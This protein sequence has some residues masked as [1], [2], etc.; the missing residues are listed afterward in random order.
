MNTIPSLP[1]NRI[2]VKLKP[3]AERM[4]KKQHPWVFQNS[5][6]KQSMEGKAG[7]LAIIYDAKKNKFLACGLLDPDSPIRIKLLQFATPKT[8]DA[9][10]FADT[11]KSAM[12][13]RKSL[14]TTDTNSYRIL[15]GE[16]DHM[17]GF[18]AD[19]YADVLVIK[20]YSHI[21][22]PYL[23]TIVCNL[24]EITKAKSVVLRMSRL[25]QSKGETFDLQD[26]QLLYG[27]LKNEVILFR[28]HGVVFSAN[29]IHGHKTGYFLDH[30]HNRKRV[31]GMSK[32]KTVLDIFSYA[33]GFSVHALAG[34]AKA[35][36]SL[37]ISQQA[38]ASAQDNA[39]LNTHSGT[40]HIMVADAFEGLAQ[41]ISEKKKFDIV[42]IDPP[43][44]AKRESE[45]L[46]AKQSYAR[47]AKLGVQM[48][49]PS[50]ILVL[51]SCSSRVTAEEFFEISESELYRSGRNFN[52]IDK[53]YH[54][55]DHPIAFPEGAYLKC[56]YY[57]MDTE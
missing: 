23:D 55:S 28:E 2:A 27:T 26:G 57:Q 31:G 7:D 12:H 42:V 53:T 37:D 46:R 19:V 56:G 47:L 36:T 29:V 10:W 33:G 13:K 45:I 40:H 41:L 25:L 44:F 51:A 16:N 5:I 6:S 24:I 22:F 50:G 52:S 38:L 4:V 30:R 9:E 18:I 21:W 14:L 54:D 20:L 11:I 34:G 48:V 3:S 17:P 35:V 49:A 8:I 39:K 43:S 15:F 1:I 32:N